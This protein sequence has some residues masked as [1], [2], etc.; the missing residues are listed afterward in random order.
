MRNTGRSVPVRGLSPAVAYFQLKEILNESKVRATVRA[1]EWHESNPEKRR[2]KRKQSDWRKYL[3]HVKAQ[4]ILAKDLALRRHHVPVTAQ[5]GEHHHRTRG[6]AERV[7]Q[8]NETIPADLAQQVMNQASAA[9]TAAQ[10][11]L[12][13]ASVRLSSGNVSA[14]MPDDVTGAA[15]S[16]TQPDATHTATSTPND[17]D[18]QQQYLTDAER[19]VALTVSLEKSRS[20]NHQAVAENN[21]LK[22]A[23][24]TLETQ[25]KDLRLKAKLKITQ[26]QRELDQARGTSATD[27]DS[28]TATPASTAP[29]SPA[30]QARPARN[31]V[32][33]EMI[34][35]LQ[36]KV[37]S[38]SQELVSLK[39]ATPAGSVY[40]S[41]SNLE[42]VISA[43]EV[44]SLKTI[45]TATT[46][47]RDSLKDQLDS[48][49]LSLFE[50]DALIDD[51]EKEKK[52]QPQESTN[53]MVT[54]T[55]SKEIEDAKSALTANLATLE[56]NLQK[57][58]ALLN[59]AIAEKESLQSK[60]SSLESL[61]QEKETQIA[62]LSTDLHS[63]NDQLTLDRIKHEF[64]E[65]KCKDLENKAANIQTSL[66]A[67]SQKLKDTVSELEA[68]LE[69]NTMLSDRFRDLTMNTDVYKQ[70]SETTLLKL[71]T[72]SLKLEGR[73]NELEELVNVLKS[74]QPNTTSEPM[75]IGE[76]SHQQ[77]ST[78]STST[79]SN[80]S[81]TSD[82]MSLLQA[83]LSEKH[84]LKTELSQSTLQQTSL[85]TQLS[86][87]TSQLSTLRQESATNLATATSKLETLTLEKSTS[88]K[89][90]EE[91]KH[92]LYAEKIKVGDLES[93][94][95]ALKLQMS[96]LE[97]G[98]AGVV[99]AL[100]VELED[101]EQKVFELK[102]TTKRERRAS[103]VMGG[104]QQQLE[105]AKY[106]A[107]KLVSELTKKVELLEKQIQDSAVAPV[108]SQQTDTNDAG[109]SGAVKTTLKAQIVEQYEV[110][111][112]LKDE[113][114]DAEQK[115]VELSTNTK[116]ERR[117]S[118]V[119][120]G[121]QQQQQLQQLQQVEAANVA[122]EKRVLEQTKTVESLEQ[123]VQETETKSVE[124]HHLL[125]AEKVKVGE[126]EAEITVLKKGVEETAAA[127]A[128]VVKELEDEVSVA[129]EKV[130]EVNA[131]VNHVRRKSVGGGRDQ[132]EM[133]MAKAAAD[134]QVLELTKKLVE[135]QVQVKDL[136][137]LVATLTVKAEEASVHEKVIL[138]LT[139]I[140]KKSETQA[141]NLKNELDTL[142][143]VL[144]S[145]D[146]DLVELQAKLQTATKEAEETQGGKAFLMD[147]QIMDMKIQIANRQKE[148]ASLSETLQKSKA[149]FERASKENDEKIRKLKGLLG[150]ASKTLQ[151][152]KRVVAEKDEE[153]ERLRSQVDVLEK[154]CNEYKALDSEHKSN[155]DRLLM[156]IQD[157]KE[158]ASIKTDDLERQYNDT[159]LE[160]TRVRAEFQSYK[161]KAHAA[162]QQS[163]T[164]IFESKV[165]ELEEINAR[166]MR[167]KMEAKQESSL[168]NERLQLTTSELSTA[169]D[170]LVV[171]E[172]QLKR[173][174]GSSKELALLRHEVESCNRRIE[175]EKELHAESLRSKD[176]QSKAALEH[177]RLET[178]QDHQLLQS[179]IQQ[180]ESEIKSLKANLDALNVE[181]VAAK[182]ETSKA[183][184]E[185]DRAKAVA[186]QASAAAASGNF[187][188]VLAAAG[189]HTPT[190]TSMT[191]TSPGGVLSSLGGGFFS[192]TAPLLP[193][194]TVHSPVSS[195]R[196]SV[197]L[198]PAAR[199]SFADLMGKASS[200]ANGSGATTPTIASVKER[201]LLMNFQR[202][203]EL[204]AEAEEEIRM[205]VEQ[206]KVLKEE[207]RKN[208]RAEK[209]NE[210][211][212]KQQNVEYLKNVVLSFLETDAKEQLLPVI[213]KV[214]EL[215]PDEV[216]RVKSAVIGMEDEKLRAQLPN[217]GFF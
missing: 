33:V 10:S 122:A 121:L 171:F 56:G 57:N 32:D 19:I 51:L 134:K 142:K 128:S 97:T 204:L 63:T 62:S 186:A 131:A 37:E 58:D 74:N 189:G 144:L 107:E 34:D 47:E 156:E 118:S 167:E 109:E 161:V 129:R 95:E 174:E 43:D 79:T 7:L 209:R 206:E 208:E 84:D 116:R 145:K 98:H 158:I 27:T 72:E 77:K 53:S 106:A 11:A 182:A 76:E 30:K 115:V 192:A 173:Y 12:S 6:E 1:Q 200:V 90:L 5:E 140:K 137:E 105:A 155:I 184:A 21:S 194:S 83:A 178:Q 132:Q 197:S 73:V 50:K 153:M 38:L 69:T 31:P 71:K 18:D 193:S 103:S 8:V 202:V 152:S 138:E 185:A 14:A 157:E 198:N 45:I 195:R 201:E 100:K 94:V 119:S 117:A 163:S 89:K 166:L 169:L 86:A 196:E 164:N 52:R 78:T 85:E 46:S 87:L 213:S 114:R 49:Q 91:F 80:T 4:V 120:A 59:A 154:A 210:L 183:I 101:A 3:E 199:E 28:A 39:T 113:L 48:L 55:V 141:T 212:V 165:V 146:Q 35:S 66:S 112:S 217:F 150:Q 22:K 82:I 108:E 20:V 13:Q 214:L 135:T 151:E 110:I 104:Q 16:A 65:S 162:L 177:L 123:R 70:E 68:V 180:K 203:S 2:R 15:P 136:E 93:Q 159:Q 102:S 133:M 207:I 187:A 40:H 26:L 25:L 172:T 188:S 168:F 17:G 29:A 111:E 148:V 127:H 36:K 216:K 205:L 181:L 124:L 160:L 24:Q 211:L 9:Q 130:V 99:E 88:N 147:E 179:L 139:D 176:S 81:P 61:L 170:Q 96:E 190:G 42:P 191:V 67:E 64:L 44:E 215:S 92:L 23:N 75:S 175:L 125:Y 60:C 143:E 126:L 41:I 54:V 149:E